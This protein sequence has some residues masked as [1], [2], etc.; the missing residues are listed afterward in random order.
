MA[1]TPL[2]TL[3]LA[4][5]GK[6]HDFLIKV[7]DIC[8]NSPAAPGTPADQEVVTAIAELAKLTQ[9]IIRYAE[10][11]QPVGALMPSPAAVAPGEENNIRRQR[12][13]L[14]LCLQQAE[15]SRLSAAQH[16]DDAARLRHELK[17]IAA[18]LI[19]AKTDLGSSRTALE[20]M[21]SP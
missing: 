11:G 19:A 3:A 16:R 8:R 10:N 9:A 7:L 20:V 14:E 4:N 21:A 6:S 5:L 1:Q 18:D 2:R 17:L 12:I 13:I 15:Q